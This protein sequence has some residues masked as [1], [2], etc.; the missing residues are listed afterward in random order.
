M[1]TSR[2]VPRPTS[3][4]ARRPAGLLA[5][6]DQPVTPDML[7][8]ALPGR[9]VALAPGGSGSAVVHVAAECWPFVRTGGLGEAVSALASHQAGAGQPAAVVLPLYRAAQDAVPALEPVGPRF[10]VDVGGR[11]EPVRLWRPPGAPAG[12]PRVAFVEHAAAFDRAGVYGEPGADYPDNA[13]RFAVL[14]QAALTALPWLVPG[15]R[16]LHAHDWHAALALAYLHTAWRGSAF[17]RRLARVVSVHNVGYQGHGAPDTLAA[18]G[19]PNELFDWRLFEWYGR[20]NLLKGGVGLAD[21]VVAVSPTHAAELRTPEGGHGLHAAFAALGPRLDGVLNGIDVARWDPARDRWI[22]RR[23]T[24]DDPSG[25]AACTAAL[26]RAAGLP[27]QPGV[28]V[29]GMCARLVAQKGF[30]LLLGGGLPF[31]RPWQLVLV[32]DGEAGYQDALRAF[33]AAHPERVAGPFAF[34][35]RLEHVLLAGADVLLA[36]SLYEPSGLTQLRAQRYGA[37]PVARRVGGLADSIVD[38]VTG[39]LFDAYAPAALADAVR[40][41]LDLHAD[42]A[43]WARLLRASMTCDVGWDRAVAQYAAVYARARTRRRAA[44]ARR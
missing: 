41:A 37:V 39:L 30:D 10:A 19:L 23:F 22:A 29:L 6:A 11:A 33:A 43:A 28:P 35:D 40:R 9:A 2:A 14:G 5:A 27:E 3:P 38:G 20:V 44:S 12:G 16:V 24:A 8:D 17:H 4:W 34:D 26:R 18:L 25:K 32:G 31:E 1:S 7:P 13:W 15:A 21:A 42:P 36:P